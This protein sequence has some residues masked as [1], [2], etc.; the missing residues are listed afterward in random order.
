MN[1]PW[2]FL[3]RRLIA[4]T[5]ASAMWVLLPLRT[6]PAQSLAAG[7][8]K[9]RK[10]DFAGAEKSLQ[11]ALPRTRNPREKAKVYKFLGISQ[12]MQGNKSGA[13]TSFRSALGNDPGLSVSPDEVLDESIISAFNA[14]RGKGGKGPIVTAGRAAPAISPVVASS[15]STAAPPAVGAEPRAAAGSSMA[16]P[17]KLTRIRINSN[18]AGTVVM[19]GIMAGSTGS[20]IDADPGSVDITVSAAGYQSRAIRAQVSLNQETTYTVNLE[21]VAPKPPPVAAVAAGKLSAGAGRPGREAQALGGTPKPRKG[22]LA[23]T[24]KGGKNKR[25]ATRDL[26][27]P[28]DDE[29]LPNTAAP[30][31]AQ[32]IPRKP[33]MGG[34]DLAGE[35]SMDAAGAPPA[36]QQPYQAPPQTYQ[37]QPYAAPPPQQQYGGQPYGQ[38]Y[39]QQPYGQQQYYAPPPQPYYAPPP[40]PAYQAPPVYQAPAQQ[41]SSPPPPPP[42]PGP[43]QD[44]EMAYN[45]SRGGREDRGP[46]ASAEAKGDKNLFIAA[47][48]F[49]AGQYQNG[50]YL[51]G[52][53]FTAAEVG[54]ILMYQSRSAAATAQAGETEAQLDASKTNTGISEAEKQRYISES[55]DRIATLTQQANYGLYAFAGLWAAGAVQAFLYDVPGTARDRPKKSVRRRSGFVLVPE[56]NGGMEL[57]YNWDL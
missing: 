31:A 8:V 11:Q 54:G 32:P 29:D 26:F 20:P 12:Y 17:S 15:S 19:D 39:G 52:A 5:L 33:P 6:A 57:T 4:W 22:D 21:K 37:Q 51:L 50:Q 43:G 3:S 55:D 49:G 35:F 34:R 53:F 48:P 42:P 1:F 36:V 7:E 45:P 13:S 41:F 46:K 9:Y 14:Q 2:H 23:L 28:D 27:V 25:G 47:L 10:G 30:R 24:G 40:Q 18:V 56:A 44:R 16:R 38:P